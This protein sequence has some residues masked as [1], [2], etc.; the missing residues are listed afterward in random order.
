[1]I[2][3]VGR[4]ED[5]EA[6]E[7]SAAAGGSSPD[8]SWRRSFGDVAAGRL[9]G[10]ESLYDAFAGPIFGLALWRTGSVEDAGDVVQEV[11]VRLAERRASLGRVRN[12][13]AWLLSVAHRI[14]VDVTR[15]R[16]RRAAEPIEHFPLLRATENDPG[17]ASDAAKASRTLAALPPV[18]RDAIYLRLFSGC[19]FQ[20]IGDIMRVPTFTAAS[21]YRL[22]IAK[23]RRLMGEQ[24]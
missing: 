8:E 16:R 13:K 17:R 6:P 5:P 11:F 21:R 19:T 10:L 7:P 23:L 9:S 24:R 4:P 15:R 12:P 22:G 18:Q 14:A 3:V 20:A 2:A 1:M